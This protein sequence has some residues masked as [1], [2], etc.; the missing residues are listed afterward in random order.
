[1]MTTAVNSGEAEC[2][3][4]SAHVVALNNKLRWVCHAI[5]IVAL[6]WSLWGLG[7]ISWI[8]GDR[9]AFLGRLNRLF[10]LDPESVTDTRYCLAF[11]VALASWSVSTILVVCIWRLAR[12]YLEGHV[13][14]IEAAGRLRA[15]ALAGAAAWV[16]D[17]LA[18]PLGAALIS[19]ALLRQEPLHQWF[20]PLDLLHFMF[21]GFLFA[22][23][24]VF[25]T[26]AEIASEN[27]Q[28][29]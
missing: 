21:F 1:M 8:Y 16:V 17:L 28:F 15:V 9:A 5:Q 3:G 27:A 22:L 10:G 19:S 2:G 11:A 25:R 24:V 23:S 20:H 6:I 13:F 18:R 14:T 26:A 12:V 7:F 4:Q 29:V